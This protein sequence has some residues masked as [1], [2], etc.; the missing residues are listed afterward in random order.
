MVRS[1]KIEHKM[2]NYIT[3]ARYLSKNNEYKTVSIDYSPY[4]EK[5]ITEQ[6]AIEQALL[7]FERQQEDFISW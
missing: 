6:T 5:G 4:L 2:K 1:N 3:Q 7:V